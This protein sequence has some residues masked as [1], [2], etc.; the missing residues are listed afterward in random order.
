MS[1]R[2]KKLYD[3]MTIHVPADVSSMLYR[4]LILSLLL[5]PVAFADAKEL[6]AEPNQSAAVVEILDAL[7]TEHYRNLPLDDE[8]SERLLES[9][10]EQLDPSKS[11]FLKSDI[12]EFGHWRQALD[13]QLRRGDLSAG[14]AMFNRYRARVMDRLEA[15]L[16]ELESGREFDFSTDEKLE[17]ERKNAPWL[18][19]SEEADDLWNRRMKDA[20]LRLVLADR[21]QDEARELLIKRY[22]HQLRQVEK[23]N[24]DD[25][26]ELYLNTFTG[27]FDPH[28]NFMS[29]RSVE[30]FRINMSLS[31][32]GIGAVLQLED[33]M[34]KVVR[35]VPGGPADKQGQLTPGARIIGVAQADEE[36]VDVVGWRLDDVVDLIRGEKDSKV[37]LQV[38][39]AKALEE[40]E[41]IVIVRDT[42]RL[43]EQAAQ[44]EVL[45]IPVGEQNYRLGIIEIPTFYMDFDAYRA[46]DPNYKSTTRDVTRILQELSRENVDGIIIDLRNNGGGSLHEATAL[47]DLFVDPGPVVQIRSSDQRISRHHRARSPAFY[48]GPLL[49]LI[50]R[51]S[52]SASE[53]FAGAIQDYGRGL[54]VG[55]QS[56]GKGTVQNILPLQEGQLKLTESKFYRISGESTQHRGIVPDIKLPELYDVSRI[57]ESAQK[58]ALPWDKIRPVPYRRLG[59][60]SPILPELKQRHDS[61][62]EVD[63]DFQ[64][65]LRE[66]AL[67]DKANSRTVVSLNKEERLRER[68]VLEQTRL[69]LANQRRAARDQEPFADL[70][71][72]RAAVTDTSEEES[73][74]DDP[75]LRETARILIDSIELKSDRSRLVQYH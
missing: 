74:L 18:A 43:E 34:T 39:L 57:G 37:R 47:T 64:L 9:Y 20:M 29:A 67:M 50:N 45:D 42:V 11:Y 73:S 8:L 52:A 23:T 40:T 48:D 51:L 16:A 6:E 70:A 31:L 46:R 36:M 35:I 60:Y 12:D 72:W 7:A 19:S 61:R 3:V 59:D 69:E 65:L 28:T 30:N 5:C 25:V 62:A 75:L 41:E 58:T 54:V 14:F 2:L 44:S 71:E 27:L 56:Y 32:E 55:S 4:I 38:N 53:I 68:E 33:E 1:N 17:T 63:T 26:F 21:D 66:L 10:L 22:R 49:V 15:N 24:A 13:D